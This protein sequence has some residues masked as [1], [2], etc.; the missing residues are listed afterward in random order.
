MK[1]FQVTLI[2]L[3]FLGSRA[4]AQNATKYSNEFLQIGVGARALGMGNCVVATT[5]DVTS[6]YWNP[7]GL[8]G[9]KE[10]LQVSLMHASYFAGIANYDYGSFA[11]K[12][13]ENSAIGLS[14]IRFGV[15][16]ILN[17]TDLIRNGEVDYSRVTTFS[18]VDYAFIGS[19]AQNIRLKRSRNNK[20]SWGTNAKV[21]H[22]KVGQFG[23]AWGFGFDVGLQMINEKNGWSYGLTGRDITSTFNNWNYTLSQSTKDIYTQTGNKIPV[24]TLEITLPRFI[25]AAAKTFNKEKYL[26]TVEGNM[27]ITTDGK[28]N[29]L[30]RTNFISLDPHV[31]GEFGYKIKGDNT[32]LYFR[33]G[34]NNIQ[35]EI[36]KN[37]KKS[38]TLVP[39]IGV[40]FNIGKFTLDYA[41]TDI[42]N[43]SA[44]LYTNVI[45][46]KL[47]INKTTN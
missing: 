32:V 47:G 11:T 41:F 38:L 14:V 8:V 3:L 37:G 23:S 33:T 20:L 1:L 30:V 4:S 42:G 36:L 26:I 22:R 25:A 12:P 35:S 17:T 21:I 9:V 40:G 5:R 29:V 18:A 46:L 6:G 31:G 13:N 10:N 34:I 27:D 28:R 24:N 7:A 45:S 19:Y 16:G 15:D 43:V 39:S 2:I 44:A